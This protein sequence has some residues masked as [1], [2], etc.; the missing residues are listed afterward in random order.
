MTRDIPFD[1]EVAER[2]PEAQESFADVRPLDELE[3][4][5]LKWRDDMDRR[6]RELMDRNDT[7]PWT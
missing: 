5:V 4:A 3:A 2:G 7:V 1:E 6:M